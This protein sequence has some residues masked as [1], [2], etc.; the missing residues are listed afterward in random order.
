MK[1]FFCPNCGSPTVFSESGGGWRETTTC[2]NEVTCGLV[3]HVDAGEPHHGAPD[4]TSYEF[5]PKAEAL[6]KR[7]LETRC[8]QPLP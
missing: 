1:I 3:I 7:N 2:V 8:Q 5:T 4:K 6:Y